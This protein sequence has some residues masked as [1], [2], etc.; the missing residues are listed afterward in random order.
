[1][2][3]ILLGTVAFIVQLEFPISFPLSLLNLYLW[4]FVFFLA[5]FLPLI[6]LVTLLFV[7][8][9]K[10]RFALDDKTEKALSKKELQ[11]IKNLIDKLND[12]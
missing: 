9:K 10:N 1:M 8:V 6:G 12:Y 7:Q 2:S 5:I 11:Q 3:L 4:M